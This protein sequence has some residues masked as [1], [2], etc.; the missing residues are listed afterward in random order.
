MLSMVLEKSA[1]ST[2]P[3]RQ[4]QEHP[5]RLSFCTARL[6]LSVQT[7]TKAEIELTLIFITHECKQFAVLVKFRGIVGQL[8]ITQ[9][10][11]F[12]STKPG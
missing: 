4:Y 1:A 2:P 12:A 7:Q 3:T 8:N 10:T 11:H 9:A 6:L 5:H